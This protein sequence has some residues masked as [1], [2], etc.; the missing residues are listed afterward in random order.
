MDSQRRYNQV[1]RSRRFTLSR[2]FK[3]AGWRT[4][5]HL[6][7]NNRDWPE[8][9]R[10]YRFDQVYDSR[11]VGYRGPRYGYPTMP[12]Q[13][14]LLALHR[15]EL[16]NGHRPPLFAEV[17]LISSHLP[18]TRV[19]RFVPWEDVGDGSVF[20]D[21]PTLRTSRSAV[22]DDADKAR[23]AY[24]ASIDYTLSTL[25]SFVQRYGDE[26]LVLVVLGDHQPASVVSGRAS[27]TTCRSRS[28]PTTRRCSTG[29][30]AGAGT[31]LRPDR[32]A[33]VWR[34][35]AFRDRFLTTFGS[36]PAGG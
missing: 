3:R 14:V 22:L 17:D 2:A 26:D 12:D 11:N 21:V 4:V 25:F 35:N 5:G 36:T 19:P 27:A 1:T 34:M 28:S 30:P 8:G 7:I 31:G 6:P 33:P 20:D 24:S 23:A 16:A 32:K 13:Y 15:L 10:F 18:W 9:S 29:S